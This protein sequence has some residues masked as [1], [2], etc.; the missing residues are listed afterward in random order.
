MAS[1]DPLQHLVDEVL[2]GVHGRIEDEVRTLVGR[3]KEEADAQRTAAIRSARADAEA[4]A[5]D[6]VAAAQADAARRAE[7][8]VARSKEE[9]AHAVDAARA[10]AARAAAAEL[11]EARTR[12]RQAELAGA[13]RLLEAIRTFDHARSLS[14]VLHL[15]ADKTA[16]VAA[17]VAVLTVEGGR[18]RSWRLVG[19]SAELSSTGFETELDEEDLLGAAIRSGQ[20][21]TTSSLWGVKTP[22]FVQLTEG[23][24][25]FAVPLDVGGQIVAVLYADDDGEK[26]PR[27]TVPSAWPEV[28]ELLARHAARCLQALTAARI[29][30]A[31]AGST[32]AGTQEHAT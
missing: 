4:H 23:R 28:V 25:G 26:D 12:E 19:F 8:A 18:L 24:V 29:V 6:L 13:E 15:L 9:A 31:L 32:N 30:D 27:R 14:E 21:C 7:E 10:E 3:M 1:D 2:R 22:T 11:A 16:E 17:R 20:A 5:R